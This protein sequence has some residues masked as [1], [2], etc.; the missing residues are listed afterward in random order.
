MTRRSP[1]SDTAGAGN[2]I[3]DRIMLAARAHFFAY[4]YSSFTM[5]DLAAELGMSKKTL[6][7]H[8]TS[9]DE[10]VRAVIDA[11]A[12][13]ARANAEALLADPQRSF[14][15]K[16][17]A[18][19]HGMVER[20]GQLRPFVIR[21]LQRFAPDLHRHI[22][23]IRSRNVP[24]IFGR[25][26]AAGQQSGAVREDVNAPVAIEFFLH[27]IQGLLQPEV[28]QRLHVGPQ[29]VFQHATNLFFSGLLTPA[30]RKDYEKLPTT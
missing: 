10:I 30:G 19:V 11:F 29:D 5:A 25:F 4:G 22:H 17:R 15:E 6:Y 20:L 7:V 2:E 8:F 13:E 23:E 26:I 9:K 21:D 18:F 16:L 28:L 24:Y 3:R 12:A 1:I 14:A 27:A